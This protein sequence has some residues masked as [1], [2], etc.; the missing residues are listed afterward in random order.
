MKQIKDQAG[1]KIQL[2]FFI[3]LGNFF[4]FYRINTSKNNPVEN[5]INVDKNI[6]FHF[7]TIKIKSN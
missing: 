7:F 6:N 2:C 3:K 4:K 1:Q 5:I